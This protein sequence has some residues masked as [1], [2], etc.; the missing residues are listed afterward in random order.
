MTHYS[1]GP[2]KENP[3]GGRAE[4]C[5]HFPNWTAVKDAELRGL[6]AV[7]SSQ[8]S[9]TVSTQEERALAANLGASFCK[10]SEPPNVERFLD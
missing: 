8:D 3:R 9:Q 6:G 2:G 1:N 7:W 5:N 10:V 4:N